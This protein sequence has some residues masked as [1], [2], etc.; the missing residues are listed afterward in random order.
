LIENA[1]NPEKFLEKLSTNSSKSKWRQSFETDVVEITQNNPSADEMLREKEAKKKPYINLFNVSGFK[2]QDAQ[3][4]KSSIITNL[5]THQ[6]SED[7][8]PG[9]PNNK[10]VNQKDNKRGSTKDLNTMIQSISIFNLAKSTTTSPKSLSPSKGMKRVTTSHIFTEGSITKTTAPG[11]ILHDVFTPKRGGQISFS[12]RISPIKS[13]ISSQNMSPNISPSMSPENSFI[14]N[15]GGSRM[16]TYS[17]FNLK[18]KTA[19][20][21][22]LNFSSL[23][24]EQFEQTTTIK[25][26]PKTLVSSTNLLFTE[27][28]Q[29]LQIEDGYDPKIL[30]TKLGLTRILNEKPKTPSHNRY[31]AHLMVK[32]PTIASMRTK[33]ELVKDGSFKDMFT[34]LN[35]P[36]IKVNNASPKVIM[37]IKKKMKSHNNSLSTT[38]SQALFPPQ[39]STTTAMTMM[40]TSEASQSLK[41]IPKESVTFKKSQ[42]KRANLSVK[43]DR[44]FNVGTLESM[45]TQMQDFEKPTGHGE[46][47]S[48]NN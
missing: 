30:H 6:T 4:R 17:P 31:P 39:F 20:A 10:L 7:V 37:S 32:S 12:P 28:K 1:K 14:I 8:L 11:S 44:K 46:V 48:S 23:S 3:D 2:M 15:K 29:V 13:P 22:G 33:E 16:S 21:A 18:P 19:S 47:M 9:T 43:I 27:E 45:E 34:L 42:K 36:K 25:V 35:A 26:F 24:Q 5:T 38:F 40:T 41:K